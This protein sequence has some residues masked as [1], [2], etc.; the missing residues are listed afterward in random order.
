MRES[1][2]DPS[3][4]FGPF[5]ADILSYDPVDLNCLLYRM[6]MDTATIHTLLD[7]PRQAAIWAE[8]AEQR[9]NRIRRLMWNEKQGLF[10]D[11]N[12]EARRQ[13]D[14]RFVTTF[15]PLWAGIATPDEAA[16]VAANLPLF[17]RAGG[18]QTS[19]LVTGD[20]W[21]AP[22][23]WAPMQIIAA[24]GL[25]GYGFGADADRISREFLLMVLRDFEAHGTIMEKYN[26]VTGKS[27]LGAEIKFGYTSNE[28]GF[29]WT[30][31]AFLVLYDGL[32][33]EA[34]DRFLRECS[35]LVSAGSAETSAPVGRRQP[36]TIPASGRRGSP[37][38]RLLP[39]RTHG[40]AP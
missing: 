14:Y 13:S 33:P 20:Q 29:G 4:R 31:A 25:R 2:F 21:D 38:S 9:A 23:G 39:S 18:L 30:N 40:I 34:R 1:G 19:D 11:Y 7:Q 37:R 12:F 27:N 32:S 17:E 22:F 5:S 15:Y 10:F 3:G 35:G 24:E 36:I 8:R 6:E 16:R 28:I 26:V